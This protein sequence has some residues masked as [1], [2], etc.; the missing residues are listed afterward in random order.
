MEVSWVSDE[1]EYLIN[2]AATAATRTATGTFNTLRETS[3]TETLSI[4]EDSLAS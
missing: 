2:N 3:A 4:A 1:S